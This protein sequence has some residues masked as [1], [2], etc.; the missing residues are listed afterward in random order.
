MPI[1]FVYPASANFLHDAAIGYSTN[2]IA[3]DSNVIIIRGGDTGPSVYEQMTK[4]IEQFFPDTEVSEKEDITGVAT[5]DSG[6][7][8]LRRL[9]ISV[10]SIVGEG[11][12]TRPGGHVLVIDGTALSHVGVPYGKGF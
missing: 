11:N 8:P 10:P 12:G 3:D 2:L 9:N 7:Y 5:S 1:L 6:P 4:A